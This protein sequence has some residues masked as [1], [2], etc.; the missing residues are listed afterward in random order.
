MDERTDHFDEVKDPLRK[1][2]ES[3]TSSE[4][5]DNFVVIDHKSLTSPVLAYG[6][7]KNE[8]E[9]AIASPT[10]NIN[11]S[12]NIVGKSIFYDCVNDPSP[13]NESSSCQKSDTDEDAA[14]YEIDQ[15]YKND[16]NFTI[17]SN[18]LYLGSANI[19]MPKNEEE[20]LRCINEVN[21]GSETVGV[22]VKISIPNCCDGQIV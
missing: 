5:L 18:V 13:I 11:H 8:L 14:T 1:S 6:V 7:S 16:G 22:K 10:A 9:D 17:F 19:N 4:Q 12:L 21:A 3:S 2:S 20:I 15:E